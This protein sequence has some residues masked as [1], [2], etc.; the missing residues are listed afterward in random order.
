MGRLAPPRQSAPGLTAYC[1]LLG[2]SAP[3][4]EAAQTPA[5]GVGELQGTRPA[6]SPSRPRRHPRKAN[7]F[8][9]ESTPCRAAAPLTMARGIYLRSCPSTLTWGRA[10]WAARS[11]AGMVFI[12]P[13]LRLASRPQ[14]AHPSIWISPILIFPVGW[15]CKFIFIAR[16]VETGDI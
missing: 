1:R 12:T 5:G 6:L 4:V 2:E 14:P 11:G 9:K 15:L 8:Q 13:P 16:L 7:S 3:F 10:G